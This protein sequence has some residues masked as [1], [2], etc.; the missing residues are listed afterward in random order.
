MESCGFVR[1]I[2]SSPFFSLLIGLIRGQECDDF[3]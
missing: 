1:I 2:V 3:F